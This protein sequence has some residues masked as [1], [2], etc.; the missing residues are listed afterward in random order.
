MPVCLKEL[1]N[2][3]QAFGEKVEA[4]TPS[5]A[6]EKAI[7]NIKRLISETLGLPTRLRDVGVPSEAV[8]DLAE[9]MLK[10]TRLVTANPKEISEKEATELFWKMW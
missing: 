4:L 7:I 8:E 9:S 6:A 1:K 3:A 10:I 2:I 5:Q